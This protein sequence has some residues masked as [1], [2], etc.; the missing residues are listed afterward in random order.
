[1]KSAVK[2][3]F[4]EGRKFERD[5]VVPGDSAAPTAGGRGSSQRGRA[6]KDP[7]A[8]YKHLVMTGGKDLAPIESM[9]DD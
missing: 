7:D 1:M 5:L 3:A 8:E 6:D 9:L 4:A 2:E